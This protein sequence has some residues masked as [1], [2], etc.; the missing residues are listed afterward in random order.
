MFNLKETNEYKNIGHPAELL[1]QE[2]IKKY[3]K[4]NIAESCSNYK[5]DFKDTNNTTYE[6]KADK[7]S[8]LT[9][10]FYIEFSQKFSQNEEYIP[11]GISKSI[12]DY[13][14]IMN[15]D[16]FYQVKRN[17]ILHLIITNDYQKI[18]FKDNI[19][20]T[21]TKGVLIKV[22]DIKPYAIIHNI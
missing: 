19:Y 22:K 12:A 13:Y 14:M 1:A 4:V 16:T 6:I 5:Y 7:K 20:N 17:I 15:G 18:T 2:I 10:N 21:F 3:Y 11:S 9:D 8:H